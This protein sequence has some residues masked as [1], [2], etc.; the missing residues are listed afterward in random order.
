MP[1]FMSG[2]R[3]VSSL[4]SCRNAISRNLVSRSGIPRGSFVSDHQIRRFGS[5]SGVERCSSYGLMS[6]DDARVSFGTGSFIQRRHFLGCGD[7]EEGGGEL[8][9]IY[10]E[11]RVLG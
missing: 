3:A 1:P 5:L 8:S 4:I 6:N 2:L 11:R 7:G 10:E 9:K